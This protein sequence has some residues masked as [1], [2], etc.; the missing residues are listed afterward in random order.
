MAMRRQALLCSSAVILFAL[1]GCGGNNT[2]LQN[3][4]GPVTTPVSIAFQ[5]MP[6]DSVTLNS[7]AA[8]TAIVGNDPSDAGVDWALLCHNGAACGTLS[9][10]HTESGTAAT[11]T[12]PSSLSGN[13]QSVTIEA[14]ATADHSKN[15]VTSIAVTGFAGALKGTYVFQSKGT[16]AN[17]PFQLAGVLRLDGNGAI[18]SGEQTHSDGLLSV[19]DRIAGGSYY[20]GPDGRGTLTID[21][22]DPNI[23]QQGIENLSLVF[24]SSSEALIATLDDPNLESSLETSSGTLELQTSTAAPIGGYAFTVSGIDLG[25]QPMAMGGVFNIDSPKRI[26][27][28]GSVADQDDAG[29]VSPNAALSGTVTKPDSFGSVILNL[30]ADFAPTP[31]RFTGY[32]VDSLHLQLIESDIDGSG[33]GIGATAGP[34][35]AQGVSTGKF[36]ANQ[37]FAGKYVFGILG[38]DLSEFPTTLASVGEFT[39]DQNGNLKS[40]YNDETLNGLGIVISDSFTGSFS[41]DPR[42]TGRVDSTINFGTNGPGP[43]LIFYLTGSGTPPLV[44][45][46]DDNIGSLGIGVAHPQALPPFAFDGLFGLGFSQSTSAGE[47]DA[48]GQITVDGTTNTIAGTVD[49]NLSFSPQPNTLL[50]G[51]FSTVPASGRFSGKLTNTFFSTAGS[52]LNTISARFYLFDSD[53]GFFIETDSAL[54]AELSYGYLHRRSPICSE[55]Q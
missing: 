4:K 23:G 8:I 31:I 2:G 26:S 10:L 32:I 3:P 22:G 29:N 24:L 47:N 11:F 43:E 7:T 50:T 40:G 27:G 34:A 16:D 38:Q 51:T 20:L 1:A 46:A 48:T 49:T 12:P 36:T 33:G 35:V 37:S 25:F 52:A 13:S 39:A 54:T 15:L 53:H 5:P 55:C 42:G 6:V 19:S 45:D 30:T 9:P 21:T 44:L 28:P 41:L 17:G 18:T 14:F